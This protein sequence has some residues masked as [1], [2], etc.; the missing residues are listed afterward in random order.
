MEP[1]LT[2]A[3][4]GR[5][6]FGISHPPGR[7]RLYFFVEW[8]LNANF[9][10]LNSKGRLA[11]PL[12]APRSC[13]LSV[14]GRPR[15]RCWKFIPCGGR[16]SVSSSGINYPACRKCRSFRAHSLWSWRTKHCAYFVR[17]VGRKKAWYVLAIRVVGK[18]TPT[19]YLSLSEV[20]RLVDR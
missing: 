10:A 1:C 19:L 2:G 7:F 18:T 15:A 12:F 16:K 5:M 14:A 20:C 3:A 11:M 9:N 17:S 4:S 13:K 8:V 6:S